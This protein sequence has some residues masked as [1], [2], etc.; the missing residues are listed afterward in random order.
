VRKLIEPGALA[1]DAIR[2]SGGRCH[3]QH[4]VLHG[5]GAERAQ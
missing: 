4:R 1:P 2:L 5:N 3:R